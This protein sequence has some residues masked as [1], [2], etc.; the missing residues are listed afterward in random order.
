MSEVNNLLNSIMMFRNHCLSRIQN[1]QCKEQL[2]RL[3]SLGRRCEDT[4]MISGRYPVKIDEEEEE[5][6]YND[7]EKYFV[8]SNTSLLHKGLFKL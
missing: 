8:E 4:F 3:E 2:T 7:N 6:I 1:C 5:K